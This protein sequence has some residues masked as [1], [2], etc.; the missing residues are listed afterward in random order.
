MIIGVDA[1]CLSVDD[2]RLKT[3]VYY[4]A[5]N[6]LENLLVLDKKN[7]YLLYSFIPIKSG[8][9]N[10]FGD[11]ASNLVLKPRTDW[12]NLRLSGEFLL[13]KPDIFLGLSQALPLYH[14][15]KSIV[16]FHDLAFEYYP[17]FYHKTYGKLS[18]QSRFSA[19][20]CD[21]LIAVSHKTKSDLLRFYGINKEKITVIYHGINH[22][23]APQPKEK[24]KKI[25]GKYQLSQPYILSVGSLKPVKN[26]PTMI[27]A[28]NI[29]LNM[30]KKPFQFIIV[31]SDYWLDKEIIETI[32]L[33][34][35]NRQVKILGFIP[36]T[37]L[38]GLYS[39]A[40]VFLSTSYF[41]GFGLPAVEAMKCA[42]PVITSNTG[43]LPEVVG[44]AAITVDPEDINIIAQA[45]VA[46]TS[47]TAL[48]KKLIKRGL[49]Q[50]KLYSWNNSAQ[51][52]LDII[53]GI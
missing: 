13:N 10:K 29:F 49:S 53:D 16:Y 17:K 40:K 21:K 48:S 9:L 52:L 34:G 43:S 47:D 25:R 12:L 36:D 14:P 27:K 28:F 19:K 26:I 31:G 11:N 7:K 33:L 24:I 3:G 39:D 2:I 50:A 32:N 4:F 23:F 51:K 20:N 8:I 44:D 37:D 42:V 5:L 1:G 35:L 45:L 46:V 41:E 18:R 22:K 38:P 30:V 6:L 15:V